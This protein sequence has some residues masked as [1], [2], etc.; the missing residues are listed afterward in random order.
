[1]RVSERRNIELATVIR[2]AAA[3]Y[4][5]AAGSMGALAGMGGMPMMSAPMMGA[6]PAG[7]TG[8]GIAHLAQLT[9][10]SALFTPPRSGSS[11]DCG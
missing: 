7:L 1:M 10:P 6:G 3:G 11:S 2:G 8:L 9:H 4:R 5:P